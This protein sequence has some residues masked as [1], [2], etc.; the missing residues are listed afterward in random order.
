M[1]CD[2]ISTVDVDAGKMEAQH[3]KRALEAMGLHP[4]HTRANIYDHDRGEYNHRTGEAVWRTSAM[5]DRIKKTAD[6]WTAELKQ[7]YSAEIVKSQ[8]ARFGWTLK[9]NPT[10]KYQFT[11]TKR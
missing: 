7:A 6:Q 9:A 8:A 10:N 1:P 4:T 5:S 2:S 11:V 3:V